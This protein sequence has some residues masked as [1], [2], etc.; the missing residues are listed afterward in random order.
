M[1]ILEWA[2]RRETPAQRRAWAFL[3][4]GAGLNFPIVPGVHHLQLGERRFRRGP[5]RFLWSKLYNEPLLRLQC[6][7][8]GQG[9]LLCEDMP[10]IM[11]NRRVTLGAHVKLNGGQVWVAAG[12]GSPNTLVI[13]DDSG[14]GYGTAQFFDFV[15]I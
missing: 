8:V 6:D 7:S 13:G 5:L 14:I 4:F 15:T 12:G 3:K 10:K 9:L 1:G 11:G 2:H